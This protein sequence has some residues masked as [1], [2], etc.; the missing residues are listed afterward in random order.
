VPENLKTVELCLEAVKWYSSNLECVPEKLRTA[1]FYLEA[2]KQDGY[3]LEYVPNNLK[4]LELCLDAVR[5]NGYALKYVPNNLK[6]LELC[7]EAVK[8][9][10]DAL[11]FVPMNFKTFEFCLEVVK[12]DRDA[13]EHVPKALLKEVRSRVKDMTKIDIRALTEEEIRFEFYELAER[14]LNSVPP[15]T[16]KRKFSVESDFV[17]G[18]I[19]VFVTIPNH[20]EVPKSITVKFTNIGP[21]AEQREAAINCE[22]HVSKG[23]LG[24]I[25][26]MHA[27]PGKPRTGQSYRQK[28]EITLNFENRSETLVCPISRTTTFSMCFYEA[29]EAQNGKID[30]VGDI[31]EFPDAGN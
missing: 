4:T 17:T 22:G 1:E 9:D 16:P 18:N 25:V 11:E 31:N 6:T 10:S 23:E 19:D 20:R 27:S 12:Q 3:A 13:L 14:E 28:A 15:D 7:L 5:Q 29:Y 8:Q 24:G 26:I 2:V 21:S 30:S